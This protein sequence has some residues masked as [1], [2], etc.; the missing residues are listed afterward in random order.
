MNPKVIV[1]ILSYNGKS[2]LR[3]CISSYL[4]NDYQNFEVVVIDNG[5]NDE[6]KTWV[7]QNFPGVYVHRTEKNL[8]YSG[9]LN[10]GMQYAFGVKMADFVLI[11]NND[12]VA[13]KK[14]ISSLIE[15]A[16]KNKDAGFV[17]GKVYYH[18]QPDILQ[19]VG[20]S[21]DSKYWRGEHIGNREKDIGQYDEE[22]ERAWCDDIY[23]LVRYDVYEKTGG[24]DTEF[25]FQA[26][27]FDWQ[28]R[29]KKIGF[30]I[31]YTPKA[32]LWHKDSMTLGK[33][34]VMKDY[35]N[36]RN[37]LIVHLKYRT[38]EEAKYYFRKK[39][40]SHIIFT[41][42]SLFKLRILRVIKTWQGFFSALLW[43]AKN[44]R[45]SFKLFI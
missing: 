36:A 19:T 44:G 23:W 45:L 40:K 31:I 24:Y 33:Q 3:D 32:K 39:M 13:D 5:S 10:F 12:V 11:T 30:K 18:D 34:S 14:M 2:L 9:G 37:P 25:A 42:R 15:T 26:E 22:K 6:T 21:Y 27:D 8:K 1:L 17:I 7:E 28:A 41:F 38:P 43:A 29:A 20:K 35:Y 4:N 16:V